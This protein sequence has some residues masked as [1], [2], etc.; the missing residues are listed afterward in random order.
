VSN[1]HSNCKVYT[2]QPDGAAT[3]RLRAVADGTDYQ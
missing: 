3:Q 1:A 2:N